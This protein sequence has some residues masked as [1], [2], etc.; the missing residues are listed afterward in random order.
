MARI[1]M[2]LRLGDLRDQTMCQ[3]SKVVREQ[4]EWCYQAED[5]KLC[6]DHV[7]TPQ[8]VVSDEGRVS[9]ESPGEVKDTLLNGA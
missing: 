5:Q 1:L 6:Q 8:K 7:R 9:Q 3:R 4:S 2:I